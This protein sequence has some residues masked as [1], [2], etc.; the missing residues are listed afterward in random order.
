MELTWTYFTDPKQIE[1]I[2]V[3]W[4][5]H[6]YTQANTTPLAN[7]SWSAP[8]D[9]TTIH[10]QEVN[11][12][13][14][15]TLDSDPTLS[16]ASQA[17]LQ[18]I[19]N[20]IIP[21]IPLQK[22]AIIV[23]KFRSFYLHTK[24]S[25]SSSP[26]G[27]HLGHWKAVATNLELSEILVSIINISLHNS[28][29]F[30][31][32]SQVLGL[33]QEKKLGIPLIHR[34][35]TLHLVESDLNFVM[36]LFWGKELMVWAESHDAISNNQYG[37]RKGVQAQSAA[38]NKTLTLNVVRYYVDPA[39]IID[40]DA[41]ACYDRILIVL[42]CYSLLRLEIPIYL[43]RFMCKWLYQTQY[44]LKINDRITAPYQWSA[45]FLLQGT[46]LGT[47][48]SPPTGVASAISSQG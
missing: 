40:N 3:Q 45:V 10:H 41:Q 2:L 24:E 21:T 32:W 8:K 20:N 39:F 22:S 9:P 42:L 28:Y 5:Q 27:L 43:V 14:R 11:D 36:R 30:Q 17:F 44:R 7:S 16:Q 19:K 29:S 31:R 4:Q 35:H 37:G 33:L 23:E 18:E 6:H 15:D 26:S 25:K 38:L 13:L 34:F 12:I 47:G 48:W 46:E 1:N